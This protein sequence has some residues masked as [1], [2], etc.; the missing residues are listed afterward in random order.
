MSVNKYLTEDGSGNFQ[1]W[2]VPDLVP[3]SA[4]DAKNV[5]L[6]FVL[7]S[8][9]V[10]ELRTGIP[11]TGLAGRDA[12]RYLL[13]DPASPRT[14]GQ[15]VQDKHD[16]V[17]YQVGIMNV[18]CVPMQEKAHKNTTGPS[19]S[20]IDWALI[21]RARNSRASTVNMTRNL[22]M[23]VVGDALLQHLQGR[24]GSLTTSGLTLVAGGKFAQRYCRPVASNL[25]IALLCVPHPSFGYWNRPAYSQ[26]P[27]L[28]KTRELFLQ[29]A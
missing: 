29:W 8:P 1:K 22:A 15:V 5:E 24:V 16:A 13:S 18:S 26:H 9:H 2:H 3:R 4:A 14:L 10:T 28:M 6:L 20:S 27:D 19:L 11:V 7:E 17:D 12:L 21:K 25:G 23:N